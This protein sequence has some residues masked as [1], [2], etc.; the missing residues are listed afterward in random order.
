MYKKLVAKTKNQWYNTTL[1]IR[2]PMKA[3]PTASPTLA[4]SL[5]SANSLSTFSNSW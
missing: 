5:Y 4:L 3:H 1:L 2:Y